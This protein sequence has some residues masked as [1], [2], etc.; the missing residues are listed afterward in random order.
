MTFPL[1][2]CVD[3][4][5]SGACSKNCNPPMAPTPEPMRLQ[6]RRV[7][8]FRL[9][10]L[11]R[12]L[13]GRPALHCARPGP[14]GNPFILDREGERMKPK[15]AVQLYRA[16]LLGTGWL[17]NTRG[18]KITIADVKRLAH[19]RNCAC[20]CRVDAPYCHVDTILEVANS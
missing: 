8:G 15:L 17:V 18:K 1:P 12:A 11:S 16:A 7:K 10:E 2:R 5:P 9:Q 6:L 3:C 14:L 13:N 20:F 4:W 19:G